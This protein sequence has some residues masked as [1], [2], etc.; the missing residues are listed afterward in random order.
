MNPKYHVYYLHSNNRFDSK[1]D[2]GYRGPYATREEAE[3]FLNGRAAEQGID[4]LSYGIIEEI[5][6]DKP[7]SNAPTV[8]Q[9][10]YATLKPEPI[11]IIEGWAL[12]WY[13]GNAV[14][15]IARAGKKDTTV[16]GTIR[17]LEKAIS[18]LRREVNL[19]GTGKAA[20]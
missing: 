19:L 3:G 1:G 20:W 10:H 15:Y 9:K 7:L 13:R 17:D 11:E 8:T 18:Y 12:N 2:T 6:Q 16:E 14:K 5:E 4:P